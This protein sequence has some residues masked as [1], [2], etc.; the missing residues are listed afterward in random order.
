MVEKISNYLVDRMRLQMTDIDDVKAEELS[1]GLQVLIG[2][3]PKIFL[4]IIV[5]F[6]LGIGDLTLITLLAISP[7]KIFS[8]GIHLKTH[9][10]CIVGTTAFYCG[11]AYIS[12]CFILEPIYIKYIV[13][14]IIWIFGMVM[15]KLYA[16]ADT[17]NVPIISKKERRKK[18][19]ASYITLTLTLIVAVFVKDNTVCNILILGTLVQTLMITKLAYRITNNKYGHEVYNN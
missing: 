15:C 4:L 13:I 8:G 2:E 10:G 17:E 12:T 7:Y 5:A 9:I 6:L 14:S 11:I 3:V 16:P 1:Y 18:R 19:I